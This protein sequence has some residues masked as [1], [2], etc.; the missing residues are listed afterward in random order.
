MK[1]GIPPGATHCG[2]MR[3]FARAGAL[4]SRRAYAMMH[5]TYVTQA[6]PLVSRFGASQVTRRRG[7]V[8]NRLL[9][10]LAVAAFLL[11]GPAAVNSQPRGDDRYHRFGRATLD[12]VRAD[13]DNA[14][15][16]LSYITPPDMKRFHGVREGLAD[17]Q[18][19][20]ER[21]RYDRA[22]LDKAIRSL[23]SLVDRGRL[24]PRDRDLLAGDVGQLVDL[25]RRIER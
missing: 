17:F 7:I 16:N 5:S 20:W 18:R 22:A 10:L 12:R 4:I 3:N 2:R 6:A 11:T 21:G 13:L 1:C 8:M 25:Q 15:R 19:R 24:R 23:Q 9:S 14:A